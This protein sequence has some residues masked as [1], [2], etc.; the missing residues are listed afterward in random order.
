MNLSPATISILG[1]LLRARTG[2]TLS[3]PRYYLLESVLTPIARARKLQSVDQLADKIMLGSDP[4]LA[5][6]VVEALLNNESYFFRDRTAFTLLREKALPLLAERRAN[7][8]RLRIWCAGASTG[9]EPYSI[10]ML[11]AETSAA[12]SGWKIE[13]L[14]TDISRSAI[15]RGERGVYSQFEVQRGLHMRELTEHF[16]QTKPDW[17]LRA[18]LRDRVQFV[19]HNLLDAPPPGSFDLILCRNVLFYFCEN[20]RRQVFANLY[21]A[22]AVDGLLMLGA[23]ET[24]L[25]VTD[26]FV[27]D[28][29]QRGLYMPAQ[30]D[31]IGRTGALRLAG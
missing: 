30:L 10:A 11:V 21:Q 16:G 23:A 9:Q 20:V 14:A 17:Q 6:E 4:A 2:Q 28:R 25:G 12:W 18:G 26:H 27:P 8:R 3:E 13:I 24:V 22:M 19:R 7:E 5:D 31:G 1:Q 15:E 29:R